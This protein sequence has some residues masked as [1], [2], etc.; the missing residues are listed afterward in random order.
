MHLWLI[1]HADALPSPRAD[2]DF[3]RRLSP[4]GTADAL[5]IAR[6]LERGGHRVDSLVSSDAS[7]ARETAAALAPGFALAASAVRSDHRLYNAS[8]AAIVGVVREA[9]SACRS[10]A[11]VGHNP[12]ISAI[13]RL[14]TDDPATRP[15]PTL[16]IARLEIAVDWSAIESGCASLALY[17]DPATID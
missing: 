16:G 9:P 5:R 15:L 10:L 3:A 7:R 6:W 11:V 4:R 17:L 12:G 1:R 2:G 14:L 8:V 13:V